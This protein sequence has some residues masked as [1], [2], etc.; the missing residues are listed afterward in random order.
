MAEW[1]P[2]LCFVSSPPFLGFLIVIVLHFKKNVKN[3]K[4]TLKIKLSF[5]N[6][7]NTL[8]VGKAGF[9]VSAPKALALLSSLNVK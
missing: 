4:G 6:K 1:E 2:H 8:K 5:S 7:K 9:R 3:I